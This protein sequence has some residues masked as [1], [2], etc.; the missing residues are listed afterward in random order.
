MPFKIRTLL[1]TDCPYLIDLMDQ[2]GHPANQAELVQRFQSLTSSQEDLLLVAE[3]E[4][5][6]ICGFLHARVS[7]TIHYSPSVEIC[8]LVVSH[9]ARNLGLGKSLMDSAEQWA[10][11]KG[12]EIIL[13]RSNIKRDDAHKFYASLGYEVIGTSHF[14]QKIII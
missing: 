11:K 8:A 4:S 3:N 14:L 12:Y 5:K 13:L 7:K 10:Q 2:L 6:S 9:K 1:V